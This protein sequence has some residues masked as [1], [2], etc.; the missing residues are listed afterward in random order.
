MDASKPEALP[1]VAASAEPVEAESPEVTALVRR[2]QAGD[3]EAF[4]SLMLLY[5]RRVIALG[6]QLGLPREDALDACQN[7]FVKA[8]RHIRRFHSGRSFF[9]WLYRIAIHAVYDQRRRVRMPGTVSVDD[10][11]EGAEERLR[12]LGPSPLHRAESADLAR[13]LVA[14]LDGL[15]RQERIVFVLRDMQEMNTAEIGIILRLSPVTVRRH[16][17]SA[18]QKLRQRLFP[19]GD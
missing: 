7:A 6:M 10:V 12:D 13:K 3:A 9:K 1:S 5:E 19:A 18:R 4:G 15:T 14:G 16:C 2:A 8:F 17:M 11:R